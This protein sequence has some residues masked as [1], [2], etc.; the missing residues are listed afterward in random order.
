MQLRGSVPDAYS[1]LFDDVVARVEP[2]VDKAFEELVSIFDDNSKVVDVSEVSGSGMWTKTEEGGATDQDELIQGYNTSYEHE[3][4]GKK[5][6]LSLEAVEDDEHA[7]VNMLTDAKRMIRGGYAKM[8]QDVADVLTNGFTTAGS[9]GQFQ[10]STAHPLN[11]SSANTLDNLLSGAL[12]HDNLELAEKQ[13]S[14]NYYGEDGLP[15]AEMGT[16]M[17]IVPPA[18]RG[19]LMR[20]M[21]S[22]G[23]PDTNDNDNNRFN[24]RSEKYNISLNYRPFEF[25][26]LQSAQGGSD[27]QWFIRMPDQD[28]F[29]FYY[30][31]RPYYDKW[32][33]YDPEVMY[34]KGSCRYSLGFNNWREYFGSTGV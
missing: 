20:I 25:K 1:R 23:R 28:M 31:K 26:Y 18:L 24:N 11:A 17:L 16:R 22:R 5:V 15:I 10:F 6:S 32:M 14:D 19:V 4:F 9:D 2:T 29:R 7:V 34:F 27:T 33:E 30:R 13:I 3:K 12:S 21:D 8:N